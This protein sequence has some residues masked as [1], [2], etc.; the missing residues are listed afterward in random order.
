[1]R[2]LLFAAAIAALFTTA[3][4]QLQ[5]Q[6]IDL[7]SSMTARCLIAN[8]TL[9]GADVTQRGTTF[10]VAI[11]TSTGGAAGLNPETARRIAARL[12]VFT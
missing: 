3:P 7:T 9:D 2:R 1:M 5:A 6:S 4:G 12:S 11:P 8:C 10:T